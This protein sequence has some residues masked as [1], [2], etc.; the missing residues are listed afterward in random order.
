MKLTP[1]AKAQID[2]KM[3]RLDVLS[4]PTF[5]PKLPIINRLQLFVEAQKAIILI[6]QRF[7]RE[8]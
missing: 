8:H 5:M 1:E 4:D 6:Y 3:Q 2:A 7:I